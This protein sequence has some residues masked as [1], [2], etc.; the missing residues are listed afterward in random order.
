VRKAKRLKEFYIDEQYKNPQD[1][2]NTTVWETKEDI[3]AYNTSD[4][5]F[6]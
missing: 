4:R 1:T 2:V 5:D 6:S 3:D